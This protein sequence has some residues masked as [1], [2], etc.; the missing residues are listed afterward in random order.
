MKAQ[1]VGMVMVPT[2]EFEEGGEKNPN[3]LW[4]MSQATFTHKEAPEFVLYAGPTDDEQA[5][6]DTHQNTT[7]D[8]SNGGCTDAF[9][10]LYLD[11]VKDPT[12]SYVLFY[13]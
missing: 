13:A 11:A 1:K 3:W 5:R 7:L 6:E 4:C 8:M 9:I 2:D 10:N 12:V